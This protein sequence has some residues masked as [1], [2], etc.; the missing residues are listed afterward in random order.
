[1]TETESTTDARSSLSL[2]PDYRSSVGLQYVSRGFS[3]LF[4]FL[5]SLAAIALLGF[6]AVE[7]FS[8]YHQGDLT[9]LFNMA[10]QTELTF[11]LVRHCMHE[12]VSR[13]EICDSKS[14]PSLSDHCCCMC[15]LDGGGPL[16][17]L[18]VA[19][20]AGLHVGFSSLSSSR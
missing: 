9:K 14:S 1:M 12:Q 6:G 13:E 8:L 18:P 5:P 17:V 2:I 11:D 15:K 16:G 7:M 4:S 10:K 19:V 3:I 20:Q